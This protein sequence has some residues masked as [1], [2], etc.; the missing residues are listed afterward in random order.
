MQA[1]RIL[2]HEH[3]LIRQYLDILGFAIERIERGEH[4]PREFFEN[5][6]LFSRDFVD[7]YHH[8]K[9]EH[10]MFALLAQEVE[11]QLDGAIAALRYQHERGR[12]QV[13][14]IATAL[15]GYTPGPM[16]DKAA[17]E[18]TLGPI[19]SP[20]GSGARRRPQRRRKR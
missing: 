19:A 14:A 9:E 2:V 3:R 20:K 18:E 6:V 4:P 17:I 7:K 10:Q 16:P 15:D 1:I 13:S 8:Y 11:G 5:A 12:V